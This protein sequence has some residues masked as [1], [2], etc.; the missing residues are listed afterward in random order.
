VAEPDGMADQLG[1]EAMAVVRA[2]RLLHHAITPTPVAPA[3]P[4]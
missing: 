4:S 1:R 2:G 3:K